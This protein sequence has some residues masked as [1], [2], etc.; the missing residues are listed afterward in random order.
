MAKGSFCTSGLEAGQYH[1]HLQVGIRETQATTDKCYCCKVMKS[2]IRDNIFENLT[3]YQLMRPSQ[4]GFV[5]SR[6]TQINLLEYME[7][8]SKLVDEGH[9]V[10]VVYC[11]FS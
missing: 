6:S 4:H 10:D 11:D 2:M 5:N 9:S 3:R 1:T 8:L 7:K